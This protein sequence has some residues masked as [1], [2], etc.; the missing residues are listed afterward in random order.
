MIMS[1]RDLARIVFYMSFGR[2]VFKDLK[3]CPYYDI[4]ESDN[5]KRVFYWQRSDQSILN[6]RMAW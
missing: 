6:Q 1:L 5:Y 2:G 4:H 3:I